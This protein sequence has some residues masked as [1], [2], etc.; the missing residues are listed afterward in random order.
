MFR[1]LYAPV[2]VFCIGSSGLPLLRS[3]IRRLRFCLLGNHVSTHLVVGAVSCG[4]H[5]PR[6]G[7]FPAERGRRSKIDN[8]GP[9]NFLISG[10]ARCGR[11]RRLPSAQD[12][13]A[14]QKNDME[15]T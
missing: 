10:I 4:F 6:R 7:G 12:S 13:H 5:L 2:V 8:A 1:V 11:S 15:R 3:Y 14:V 9:S